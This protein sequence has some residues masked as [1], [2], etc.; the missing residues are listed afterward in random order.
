MD[1]RE[2]RLDDLDPVFADRL[3][4]ALA[5]TRC[6]MDRDELGAQ[7]IFRALADEGDPA[8]EAVTRALA[9]LF[10]T[11]LRDCGARPEWISGFQ[12]R[13]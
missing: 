2:I 8:T 5:L 6:F 13:T 9:G 10:G 11:L 4:D 7:V 3:R 12:R 1:P